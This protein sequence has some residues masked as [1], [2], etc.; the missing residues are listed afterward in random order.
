MC[1]GEYVANVWFLSL[2]KT[3]ARENK[4]VTTASQEAHCSVDTHFSVELN[5]N[6][7]LVLG[8]TIVLKFKDQKDT[9]FPPLFT[10]KLVTLVE[11][12][13]HSDPSGSWLQGPLG[14]LPETASCVP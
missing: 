5:S 11:S 1:V 2:W 9:L 10:D 12:R 8:A 7:L 3:R 6:C 13:I 14:F 4:T